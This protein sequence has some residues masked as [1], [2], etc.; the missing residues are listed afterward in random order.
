MKPT[1]KSNIHK[2]PSPS[3]E[4]ANSKSSRENHFEGD[5]NSVIRVDNSLE[6]FTKQRPKSFV[7]YTRYVETDPFTK[8]VGNELQFSLPVDYIPSNQTLLINYLECRVKIIE[9]EPQVEVGGVKY[10]KLWG[11][12]APTT[13]FNVGVGGV[14]QWG[15]DILGE[16]V[17][18]ADAKYGNATTVTGPFTNDGF[19]TI[20]QNVLSNGNSDTTL[21]VLPNSDYSIYLYFGEFYDLLERLPPSASASGDPRFQFQFDIR[22]HLLNLTDSN[23]IDQLNLRPNLMGDNLNPLNIDMNSPS[24]KERLQKMTRYEGHGGLKK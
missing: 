3:R 1:D 18:L 7:Y 11:I 17:R 16:N 23:I 20:F 14:E 8:K 13:L 24:I 19:K 22:G 6:F 21:F 15:F 9:P 5:R 12:D 2:V 4:H 10:G